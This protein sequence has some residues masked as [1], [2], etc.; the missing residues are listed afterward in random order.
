MNNMNQGGITKIEILVI[1]GIVGILGLFAIFAVSTA[2]ANTRDAIRLSDVRQVQIGLELYFNDS[3]TYPIAEEAIALG[4]ASAFCLKAD[5]F[6]ASCSPEMEKVYSNAIGMPP[7]SGLKGLS[8]C[9][10]NK[11]AYCYISNGGLFGIQFELENNQPL[12][13]LKKGL[14]C[15]T[16]TGF[17][18]GSCQF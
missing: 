14:N 9:D 6:S 13:N 11:N 8:N 18:V 7:K 17:K 16:P 10:S 3:S 12:L 4:N 15:I 2:R 5:G 1:L